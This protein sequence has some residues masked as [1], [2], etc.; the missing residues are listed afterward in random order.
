MTV[1][2]QGVLGKIE[3]MI[4]HGR[5]R[6]EDELELIA[7]RAQLEQDESLIV[8]ITHFPIMAGPEA[9]NLILA[10]RVCGRMGFWSPRETAHVQTDP[11]THGEHIGLRVA[12]ISR[13][14][15]SLLD[16]IPDR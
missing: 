13:S 8:A 10:G 15:A 4:L 11:D 9:P 5:F 7:R 12:R 1:I 2:P 14:T 16:P 3:G 6:L